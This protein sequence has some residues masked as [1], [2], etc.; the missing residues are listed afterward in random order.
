MSDTAG[1]IL[2]IALSAAVFGAL[3]AGAFLVIRDTA[4]QRGRWGLCLAKPGCGRCGE[5]MPVVRMPASWRQALWGGW[6]CPRC[7]HELDKYGRPAAEQPFPAKWSARLDG[8]PRAGKKDKTDPRWRKP[9]DKT[10]RGG[11]Y[12]G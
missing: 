4:R 10:R 12:R 1:L 5:A 7:G 2:V 11:D 3:A 9:S 8:E 6:T